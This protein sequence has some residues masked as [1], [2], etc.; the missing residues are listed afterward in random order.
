MCRRSGLMVTNSQAYCVI[1][2]HGLL[3]KP[4]FRQAELH[5]ASK[6]F[7]LLPIRP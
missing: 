6:L 7:E 2:G 1:K 4:P 3:H 5:Q